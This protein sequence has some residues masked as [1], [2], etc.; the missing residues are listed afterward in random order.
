MMTATEDGRVDRR[1]MAW[2]RLIAAITVALLA[3]TM[4]SACAAL[5]QSMAQNPGQAAAICAGGGALGGAAIGALL[6]Q[7]N[8]VRGA[9]LGALTGAIAGGASCF[10]I[11]KFSSSPLKD[12]QQTQQETG[13]TPAQGTVVR[14]DSF[15]V[16][17]TIVG[18]GQKL[19][20]SGEYYVMTPDQNADLPV[21]ENMVVSFYDE[22]TQQW[23]EFGRAQN[24]VTVKPGKR[25][26]NPAEITAPREPPA[27]RIQVALQVSYDKVSDQRSREVVMAMQQAS[28]PSGEGWT[29]L[30]E[31]RKEVSHAPGR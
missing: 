23:R 15:T 4:L 31:S 5:Q 24:P 10:A 1:F 20:F 2:R 3:V 30:V 18:P 12:Y 7:G 26:L 27:P 17:P 13:Y 21:V 16:D 14:V 6:D 29:M 11:A 19:T 8:A 25:R 9:L 28:L 22:K